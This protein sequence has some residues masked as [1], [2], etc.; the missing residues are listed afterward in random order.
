MKSFKSPVDGYEIMKTL[1][2][3]EGIKVGII[4]KEIEKAILDNT[5]GNNHDEAFKFMMDIKDDIL[6]N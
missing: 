3:N 2:L 6:N 4:K 1:K 5:I